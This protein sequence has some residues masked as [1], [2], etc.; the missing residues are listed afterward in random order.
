MSLDDTVLDDPD[1][2]LALDRS[3]ML[4][5]TASAGAAIRQCL[6]VDAQQ[7][8]APLVAQ[9]RPRSLVVVGAG[10]SSVPGEVLSAVAGR[11]S[12]VPIFALG[13]PALPGW[14]G[15]MDLVVA[16]SASGATAETLTF[17]TEAQRRGSTVLG[18]GAADSPLQDLCSTSRGVTFWPVSRLSPLQ[19]VQR[20][21]SLLWALSTPLILL[22]GE[23]GLVQHA[24]HGLAGAANRLD[25]RAVECGV[26]NLTPDNPAKELS[27]HLTSGLPLVWG[28]GE[29]GA[30][31][32]RRLGRQL[33]ENADWPG[34]V[35]V[36]PEAVRTHAGLLRGPWARPPG[37][38][39]IFR[40]RTQDEQPTPRLR[41]LL[42][43]D[44][45]EHPDTRDI[46]DAVLQTCDRMDVV[47]VSVMGSGGHALEQLADLVGLLDFASIYAA[48]MQHRDPS[49]S[50]EDLD[51]R[52]GR[53]GGG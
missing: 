16:V 39:D 51:P 2:L 44:A 46:A 34:I 28:S 49:V 33:A 8:L 38:D 41:V 15:P 48:L 29:V 42:T 9:G 53:A 50:A 25:E 24:R 21:R 52:F 45:G 7:T 1:A 23:F 4:A 6:Q 35:G 36:L 11:G 10:G 14:I 17:V 32:A 27:I 12:P 18:I 47:C 37:P 5:S 26:S 3:R 30:V 22:A 31:A 19:D 20:A 43:R 13:G 40:D